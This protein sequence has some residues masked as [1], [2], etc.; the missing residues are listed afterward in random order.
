ME[1]AF[2]IAAG[3]L[4]ATR[5]TAVTPPTH[6]F[7]FNVTLAPQEEEYIPDES[8]GTLHEEYRGAVT[9]YWTEWDGEGGADA[10]IAPF[11]FA[12]WAKHVASPS[13]P[14]GA[15]AARLW[16]YIDLG[17]ADNLKT[18][19]M[20]WK[21]PTD[22][23]MFQAPYSFIDELSIE[24]DSTG[25]DGVTWKASGQAQKLQLVTVPTLPAQLIGSLLLPMKKKVWLDLQSGTI[26]TTQL[27][28]VA[29]TS[30]VMKNNIV[31]KFFDNANLTYTRLGRKKR[32]LV[33]TFTMEYDETI[34]DYTQAT[35]PTLV[36]L[37]VRYEGDQIE[38]N[39]NEYIEIDTY[40]RL[41][42]EGWEDIFDANR[43]MKLSVTSR[44]NP[45]LGSGWRLAAQNN[46]T[47]I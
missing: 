4:E 25:K 3:A 31:P 8:R 37:R 2:E 20:Y 40:G 11:L 6:V 9:K 10:K 29:K 14:V 32:K 34:Y 22:G 47:T 44:V 26:G 28:E 23:K 7:P 27:S 15:T 30:H 33:T 35:N 36:G 24:A 1:K 42:F 13:T 41:K 21:D 17:T 16:E 19:T 5:G 12:M 38:A 46:R 43:G 18:A 45:T 39:F